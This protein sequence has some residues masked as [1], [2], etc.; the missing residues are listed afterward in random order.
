MELNL[1]NSLSEVLVWLTAGE[2]LTC[3]PKLLSSIFWWRQYYK[4]QN[5]ET[6][7]TNS[8]HWQGASSKLFKDEFYN[9]TWTHKLVKGSFLYRHKTKCKPCILARKQNVLSNARFVRLHTLAKKIFLVTEG[10][11]RQDR[12]IWASYLLYC[13]FNVRFLQVF[14]VEQ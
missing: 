5:T 9:W 3:S 11:F 14:K 12:V 13:G 10:D 2:K 4:A 7:C 1:R 8:H 6:T